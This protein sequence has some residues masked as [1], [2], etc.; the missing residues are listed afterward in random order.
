MIENQNPLNGGR[1]MLPKALVC[2]AALL[3]AL[4]SA[5]S[6]SPYGG[7]ESREIK[8]LSAQEVSDLLSGRGMG[9]ARAAELNGY[10]GP[11]HVL[12][13][14]AELELSPEQASGTQA[15]FKKV[16][17]RASDIGRQ[18]VEEERAL[19]R[20]FSSRSITP[21]SLRSSLERLATLQGELRRAHLET[22]L[23]QAALLSDAQIAAYAKLRGYG[24]SGDHSSHG[25]RH[26]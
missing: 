21:A 18:L 4:G 14:A 2:A 25:A 6:Q 16:K 13:L 24:G 8:A 7:Q 20:Q 19:D 12:E 15:L 23:E 9:L 26:R 11:M 22:H 3:T 17:A 5:H 1:N 10:P